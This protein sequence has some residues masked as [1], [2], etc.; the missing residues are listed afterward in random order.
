L[1]TGQNAFSPCRACR[2]YLAGIERVWTDAGIYP[3]ESDLNA[4]TDTNINCNRNPSFAR[5]S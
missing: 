2:A 4:D 3:I 5:S 1:L